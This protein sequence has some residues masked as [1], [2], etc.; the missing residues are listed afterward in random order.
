MELSHLRSRRLESGIVG[1][2]MQN[3]KMKKKKKRT[4]EGVNQ[5]FFWERKKKRKKERKKENEGKK[6]KWR[7]DLVMLCGFTTPPILIMRT[8]FSF[9]YF[10]MACSSRHQAY[11][12]TLCI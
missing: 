10:H 8:V 12:Y 6:R 5:W 4:E 9:I 7:R 3:R 2:S 11:N 1:I